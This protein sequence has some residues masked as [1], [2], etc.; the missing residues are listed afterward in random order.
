MQRH[1]AQIVGADYRTRPYFVL[2]SRVDLDGAGGA[3]IRGKGREWTPVRHEIGQVIRIA[4]IAPHGSGNRLK[5]ILEGA[6]LRGRQA[7]GDW[8]AGAVRARPRRWRL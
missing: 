3:E 1:V 5:E 6:N 8:V 7:D 2:D 4:G